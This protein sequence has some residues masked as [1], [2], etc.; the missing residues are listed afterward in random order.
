M[1]KNN[2]PVYI[3]SKGRYKKTLTACLFDNCG[4]NYFIA[5]EPQEYNLYCDKLG[6]KNL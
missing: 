1:G 2:F 3:I 4:I 5:V 6:E